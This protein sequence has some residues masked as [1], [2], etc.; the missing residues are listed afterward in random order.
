MKMN[1][2]T[3][4]KEIGMMRAI[5]LGEDEVKGMIRIE[6][7]LYGLTSSITGS[8]L[9]SLL[10]YFIHKKVVIS[11]TWEFPIIEIVVIFIATIAITTLSSVLSSRKLFEASIID[12]IRTVE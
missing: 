7:L 11:T 4:N 10:I 1:V 6:G 9:G 12:S 3:R 2:I 5:G 8:T